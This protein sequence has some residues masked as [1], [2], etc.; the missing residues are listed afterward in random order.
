M[1]ERDYFEAGFRMALALTDGPRDER[2]PHITD[3]QWVNWYGAKRRAD[4]TFSAPMSVA[5]L[6]PAKATP[7]VANRGAAK[8]IP[9]TGPSMERPHYDRV[10]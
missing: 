3:D 6:M 2:P 4:G 8:P 1:T 5:H 9:A 7:G 10:D